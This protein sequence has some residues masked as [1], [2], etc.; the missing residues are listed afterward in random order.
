MKTKKTLSALFAILMAAMLLLGTVLPAAAALNDPNNI[1]TIGLTLTAPKA[2]ATV[3][4]SYG[5]VTCATPMDYK[6]VGVDWYKG[7]ATNFLNDRL[8]RDENDDHFIGGH[9][10]TVKVT[11]QTKGDRKWNLGFKQNGDVDYSYITATVN[12]VTATLEP[13]QVSP[14]SPD[15]LCVCYTFENIAVGEF[16]PYVSIIGTPVAGKTKDDVKVAPYSERQMRLAPWG[17]DCNWFYSNAGEWVAM[18]ADDKFVA[19]KDYRLVA[20]FIPK[21]GFRFSASGTH[22]V[23]DDGYIYG[24]VNGKQMSM[25]LTKIGGEYQYD[26]PVT[27]TY[28]FESCKAQE[29]DEVTFSGIQAPVAGQ[30]PSYGAPTMGDATYSLVTDDAVSGGAEYGFVNGLAWRLGYGESLTAQSTFEQGAYYTLSFFIRSDDIY[31]FTDFVMGSANVGYVSV[32]T[33]DDPTLAFVTVDFAP[34]G[35]GVMNTVNVGGFREPVHGASPDGNLLCGQGYEKYGE[36]QWFEVNDSGERMM[37]PGDA[38]VYGNQYK[39]VMVLKTT[40]G[41]TFAARS[42]LTVNVNGK[43]ADMLAGVANEAESEYVTVVKYFDCAK[44]PINEVRVTVENPMEGKTPAQQIQL[45]DDAYIVEGFMFADH[46]TGTVLNPDHV[47]VGAKNYSL[48]VTIAAKEGYRIAEGGTAAFINGQEA[49]VIAYSEDRVIFALVLL[50]EELPFYGVSFSDG[51]SF[52]TKAGVVTLPDYEGIIGDGEKFAGWKL[53][54]DYSNDPVLFAGEYYIDQNTEFVAYMVAT[55]THKHIYDNHYIDDGQGMHYRECIDEDCPD[56][57]SSVID[58]GQHQYVNMDPCEMECFICGHVRTTDTG[59]GWHNYEFA[60]SEVCPTCGQHRETTHTPG[61]AANCTD[62]QSCTV[63]S[64]ILV[65]ALGHTAGEAANCGHAQTCTVCGVELAPIQGEH[66]P[67]AAATCTEAQ[68]CTVCGAELA[69]AKGHTAGVEWMQDE[70]GHW[71]ICAVCNGEADRADHADADGDEL[72]DVCGY[73][74]SKG[75][76]GWGVALIVVGGVALLG[77]GGFCLYW[78]VIRKKAPEFVKAAEGGAPTDE[79]KDEE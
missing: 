79:K 60:C 52:M 41:F 40:D 37:E 62:A 24:Y 32:Q 74:I 39:V 54:D 13:H 25:K 20:Q 16:T 42:A 3:D 21:P 66:T 7:N 8:G 59:F 73:D 35:G 44:A 18:D 70:N 10:Y 77:G 61:T 63:C 68:S 58:Q 64:K 48:L 22:T 15:M 49:N 65:D 55:D 57:P 56:K 51:Q 76:P 72:C 9:S 11:L 69:P 75:L 45:G 23:G 19:G 53:V 36:L 5:S 71:H 43:E 17:E 31:R 1:K 78:F 4:L 38:F 28:D 33:M 6:V 2:G 14:E 27:F 47:Y 34:C 26:Y 67:G 30:N 29:L 46:E 12:G 50:A